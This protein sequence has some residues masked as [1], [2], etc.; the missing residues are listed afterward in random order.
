MN[1]TDE[2]PICYMITEKQKKAVNVL[3]KVL[4]V[5]VERGA[6]DTGEIERIQKVVDQLCKFDK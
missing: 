5:S 3:L 4:M 1:K 2:K 6:F